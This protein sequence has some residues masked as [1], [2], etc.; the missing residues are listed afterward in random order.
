MDGLEHVGVEI[1]RG[2]D[3]VAG[4]GSS[5]SWRMLTSPKYNLFTFVAMSP[6][7]LTTREINQPL[8]QATRHMQTDKLSVVNVTEEIQGDSYQ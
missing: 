2:G 7:L 5:S 8:I 6:L 3:V 1:I 4:V